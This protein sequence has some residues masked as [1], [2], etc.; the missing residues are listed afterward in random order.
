MDRANYKNGMG[1]YPLSTEG[2]D[3][4]QRQIELIY[5]VAELHGRNYILKDSTD[6]TEG[7]IVVDGELM[8]LEGGRQP[9]IDV[10]E[11]SETLEADGLKYD[12]ARVIRRAVYSGVQ[13]KSTRLSSEF[14][15]MTTIE[16]MTPHLMPKGA[17]VMWSGAID[18]IPAG[19]ALCD[20]ENGTPNLCGRFIVG[21]GKSSDG[22][23]DYKLNKTGGDETIK[24]TAGECAMP[25][26]THKYS[27]VYRTDTKDG[28]TFLSMTRESSGEYLR[29][30]TTTTTEASTTAKPHKNIPP[31]YV[32]AYI[33]KVK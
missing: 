29:I 13:T 24:L 33:M 30:K 26:H 25:S 32:L 9:Y 1:R 6:Y 16:A 31:Y 20:G 5:S 19:W 11:T 22:D 4:I 28:N 7:V 12:G 2:L 21:V 8:P 23:T 10:V 3:F 27:Y 17:I 14:E 15:Q 18:A